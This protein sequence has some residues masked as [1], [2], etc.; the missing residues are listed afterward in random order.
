[1]KV[2]ITIVN[3]DK[4]NPRKD[5]KNPSWFAFSNRMIEDADFFDLEHGEF[6]AWIYCLSRAS[7]KSSGE[8]DIDFRHAEKI[9][10]LNRKDFDGMFKKLKNQIC[11]QDNESHVRQAYASVRTAVH[12]RHNKQ[13]E[14]TNITKQTAEEGVGNCEPIVSNK[15]MQTLKTLYQYP[16]EIINEIAKDAWLVYLG[17]PNPEKN[18]ERFLT[19]Y[20][21]NEKEKIRERLIRPKQ[22]TW[23]ELAGVEN[24]D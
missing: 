23:Q 14:Q 10:N 1:M 20:F 2:T 11:V 24:E 21:K 3:W 4:F 17:D 7:Q 5:I 9:C 19:H 16:E 12:D 22:K 8:V 15:I 18:W 13:T 6:K